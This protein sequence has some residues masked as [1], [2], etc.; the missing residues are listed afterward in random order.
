[1]PLRR[2]HPQLLGALLIGWG[3]ANGFLLFGVLNALR[4]Q[5]KT[6]AAM[7]EPPPPG[8]VPDA[9]TVTLLAVGLGLVTLLYLGVGFALRTRPKLGPVLRG[10][11][12]LAS[13]ISLLS[14]PVGTA[15]GAY[16]L[17]V[18]LRKAKPAPPP[19]PGV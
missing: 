7:P 11:A 9:S 1:M 2:T 4:E 16:G 12:L 8:S 15:V 5:Q 18:L 19:G 10:F 14:F 3:V 6:V 13:V 17:F